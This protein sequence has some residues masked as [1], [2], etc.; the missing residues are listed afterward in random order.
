VIDY[1]GRTGGGIE[2]GVADFDGDGD[3]D[4]AVGGKSGLLIGP[5]YSISLLGK[6]PRKTTP[7][8]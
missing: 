3:L 2:I 7:V 8:R 4:F 6:M 5:S 1:G